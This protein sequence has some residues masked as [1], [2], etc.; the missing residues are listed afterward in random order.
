MFG[1]DGGKNLSEEYDLPFLGQ[2][3]LVQSIREGGDDGMPAMIASESLAKNAFR[4]FTAKAVRNI[5]LRNANMPN[6]KLIE[7]TA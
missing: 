3:P 6:T 5:A 7:V 4:E 1:K 2:V